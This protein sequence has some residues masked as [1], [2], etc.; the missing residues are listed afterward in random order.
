ML[1]CAQQHEPWK[2]LEVTTDQ[3][4]WVS[5]FGWWQRLSLRSRCSPLT[6]GH[7]I[8]RKTKTMPG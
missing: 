7:E 3:L 8:F 2:L 6:E 4:S 1:V 5:L